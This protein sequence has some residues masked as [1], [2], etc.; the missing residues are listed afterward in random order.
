MNVTIE[1]GMVAEIGY[2]KFSTFG[3]DEKDWS[4]KD[5]KSLNLALLDDAKLAGLKKLL[6][7]NKAVDGA[8]AVARDVGT[9]ISAK[10]DIKGTKPKTVNQFHSLLAHYLLGVEGHRLYQKDGDE[11]LSYYVASV[12]FEEANTR[13]Q[14]PPH[15]VMRLVYEDFGGTHTETETF[16]HIDVRGK[17]VVEAL[18]GK[19]FVAESP[20]LRKEYVRH[21]SRFES[22]C[23]LVGA[24]FHAKGFATSDVDGNPEKSGHY[25]HRETFHMLREGKPSRVVMD[26]FFE[27]ERSGREKDSIVDPTYW[28]RIKSGKVEA[29]D[30]GQNDDG[31]KPLPEIP[32]HPYVAVFDLVKH[33]RMRIHVGNLTEHVYDDHLS[34][35]LILDETD[36]K[37]IDLLVD[38]KDGGFQDIVSGK[39]GGAVVLLGGPPGVG[40]TLSAEVYAESKHMPLYNVQCSQLGTDA[41]ALEE[42]LLKVFRRARRWGAIVLLDEADVYVRERGDDIHQNAIVG[43]FLRVLEYQSSVLFLATNRPDEVDDAISSRCIA[44][45]NYTRP[46]AQRETRIWRVLAGTS[47]VEISDA[48]I[49]KIAKDGQGRSGRDV[50]NLLKLAMLV[51]Q[52]KE[53]DPETVKFVERFRP[54]RSKEKSEQGSQRHHQRQGPHARAVHDVACGGHRLPDVSRRAREHDGARTYRAPLPGEGSGGRED[55]G[56]GM[57]DYRYAILL[58]EMLKIHSEPGRLDWT[59][60]DGRVH[61]VRPNLAETCRCDLCWPPVETFHRP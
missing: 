40:K 37:L 55:V 2:K 7:A 15:V 20:E 31:T 16:H 36:K 57:T 44:R 53:I 1:K 19:G 58:N 29:D 18:L 26:V 5:K 27:E 39:G 49:A 48:S 17:T 43:V 38:H 61:R 46:D 23:K 10:E 52:G 11:W 24:Q 47:G 33:L 21:A 25:R 59:D 60:D 32:L 6:D 3:L 51:R 9:W 14:V 56:R 8:S 22:I 45:I 34:D 41:E 54:W 50:K 28:D 35:K 12:K 42:R 4:W 13:N 30:D